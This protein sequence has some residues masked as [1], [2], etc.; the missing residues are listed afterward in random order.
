MHS[1]RAGGTRPSPCTSSP[2]STLASCSSRRRGRTDLSVGLCLAGR[3]LCRL[4]TRKARSCMRSAIGANYW[5]AQWRA[6]GH[7]ELRGSC[8]SNPL[9]FSSNGCLLRALLIFGGFFFISN[10]FSAID[11]SL[12]VIFSFSFFSRIARA[13][14]SFTAM[15]VTGSWTV[16][17]PNF[18]FF[19]FNSAFQHHKRQR[20]LLCE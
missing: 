19:F 16:F 7:R 1:R 10:F 13:F 20:R 2:F 12:A 14:L 17:L 9:L 6:F 15:P 11:H 4:K 18:L 8:C 5:S 3:C